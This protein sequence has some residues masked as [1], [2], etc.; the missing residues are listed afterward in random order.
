MLSAVFLL[1]N[2][3]VF[4]LKKNMNKNVMTITEKFKEIRRQRNNEAKGEV[5]DKNVVTITEK[6]IEI[7]SKYMYLYYSF[8]DLSVDM[9]LK[10][11]KDILEGYEIEEIYIAR[12]VGLD[13]RY[14]I[15]VFFK[16]NRECFVSSDRFFDLVDKNLIYHGSCSGV[17]KTRTQHFIDRMIAIV[18]GSLENAESLVCSKKIGKC[19]KH[20]CLTTDF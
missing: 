13:S 18:V 17:H 3:F 19:Q 14:E 8:C 11:L 7:S 9:V 2:N 16:L 5:V 1:E 6:F 15:G 4:K 20:F 12:V 10:K